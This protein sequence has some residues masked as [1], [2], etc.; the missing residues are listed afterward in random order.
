MT[1]PSRMLV[2]ATAATCEPVTPASAS[3]SRTQ[4]AIARQPAATSKSWPPGTP[5]GSWCVHSLARAATCSPAA[6]NSTAR[7][8]P[9]PAS[10]AIRYGPLISLPP[11]RAVGPGGLPGFGRLVLGAGDT[12]TAPGGPYAAFGPGVCGARAWLGGQ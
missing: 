12:A 4:A 5:G 7:Q 9:V 1:T 8:L 3:A 6:V 11:S 2:A 10:I